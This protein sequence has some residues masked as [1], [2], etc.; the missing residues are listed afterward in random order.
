LTPDVAAA[1]VLQK[2]VCLL[3]AFGVGKTS[4]VRRFVQSMFDDH[5]HTTIGVKVDKKVV[6]IGDQTLTL[7][8]WDMAG[9]S[10]SQAIRISYLGGSSGYLLVAD[11]TRR[12]TLDDAL[13]IAQTATQVCGK[14]PRVLLLN[15][16]DLIEEWE[17]DPQQ[18]QRLGEAGWMA[19]R[20]SAKT[21]QAVELAF[22][23][24][25]QKMLEP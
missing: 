12:S 17:I 4:L 8:L 18:E 25:G 15:K 7:V 9:K 13:N 11:G 19:V 24:L 3:G 21:G 23:T 6:H 14:I 2:K 10:A 22:H 5:Y 1:A 16:C 20:T